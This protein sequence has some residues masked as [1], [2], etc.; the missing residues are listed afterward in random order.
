MIKSFFDEL[1]INYKENISLKNYNTYKVN[2]TCSYLVFP[3]D[4]EELVKIIEKLKESNIKY[5]VL[6]MVLI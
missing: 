2:T 1:N 3:K 4:E 6:G 5:F